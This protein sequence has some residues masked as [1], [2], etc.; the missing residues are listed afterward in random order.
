M[1]GSTI[2]TIAVLGAG[3]GGCAA[4]ADL[5]ARGYAV[6]LHARAEERLAPLR[7]AKGIRATGVQNGLF[8]IS[9]M[10]TSVAEAID[11]ADLIMLVVPS[12]AHGHYARELAPLIDG[13]VPIFL[14]PGHTGGGL[15]FVKE[16]RE[17]GYHGPVRNGETVSLTY[18]TRMEGEAEVGIYSYTRKQRFA[19]LP[20]KQTDELFD[21]VN[22]IYPETVKAT[23]VIETALANMNAVFHPPGM[24][25]NVGWIERTNGGFLFYRE[26]ITKGVGEVVRVVDDERLAVAEA[27]GVPA[28]PFLDSFYNAGLTTRE[29]RDSGSIARACEESE[30]N[31]TIKAPPSL[32]H[33]YMHEDIGY[34]LVPF[35]AL[36]SL[37]GVA[38]PTIDTI[39]HLS[40]IA[41]GIDYATEGLT[42]AKMG[43][44]GMSPEQLWRY[45]EAGEKA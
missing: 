40:S 29:A 37:A 31:K 16:L 45:I 36:G 19:A 1:S 9:R 5:T 39:V 30:P 15:H 43:L 6:H 32:D 18:I 12:V 22:A 34:G 21:I 25:M 7:R 42:L 26:G 41:T 44:E 23:S 17:A 8:P 33:R 28:R 2:K 4:A 3:H 10:T 35:A 38:T 20:G 13:S 27:L 11:G 24:I 14:N